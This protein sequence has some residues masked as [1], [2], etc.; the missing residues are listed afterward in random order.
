MKIE[1]I[2]DDTRFFW[3]ASRAV[4]F[5]SIFRIFGAK[6]VRISENPGRLRRPRKGTY[7]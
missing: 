2:S 5:G 3:R 1:N 7:K 6:D 4:L